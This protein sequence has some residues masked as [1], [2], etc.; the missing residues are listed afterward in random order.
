[1][2]YRITD[3]HGKEV[4]VRG[5]SSTRDLNDGMILF[6]VKNAEGDVVFYGFISHVQFI[7]N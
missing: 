4:L 7:Y 6:T 5:K 3:T 1:M 2:E